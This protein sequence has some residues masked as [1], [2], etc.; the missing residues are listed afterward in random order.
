[1]TDCDAAIVDYNLK[2]ETAEPISEF[3]K[4]RNVPFALA[5]GDHVMER[6]ERFSFQPMLSK[7]YVFENLDGLLTRLLNGKLRVFG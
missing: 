6:D 7:P 2:G 5:S 1:M 4:A 3:L